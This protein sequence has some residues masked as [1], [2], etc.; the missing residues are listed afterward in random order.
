MKGNGSTSL[1]KPVANQ[2]CASG[3][4]PGKHHVQRLKIPIA[5]FAALLAAAQ[6]RRIAHHHA[7]FQP[8]G[9]DQPGAASAKRQQRIATFDVV[10]RIQRRVGLE[11]VAVQ[12][13]PSTIL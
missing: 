12:Q 9:L 4:A 5:Q 10:E 11:L 3:N 1:V 8:C 2:I 7:G 6:K 13:P